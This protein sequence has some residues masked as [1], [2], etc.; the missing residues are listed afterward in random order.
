MHVDVSD[1][2]VT[3]VVVYGLPGAG[4]STLVQRTAEQLTLLHGWRA[5]VL[6]LDSWL[7]HRQAHSSSSTDAAPAFSP[8]DWH[9]AFDDFTDAIAQLLA[10]TLNDATPLPTVIFCVDNFYYASMRQRVQTM[11]ERRN[12]MLPNVAFVSVHVA[13]DTSVALLRNSQRQGQHRVP[14]AVIQRMA[15]LFEPGPVKRQPPSSEIHFAAIED[16]DDAASLFAEAIAAHVAQRVFVPRR[17]PPEDSESKDESRRATAASIVHQLDLLVRRRTSETLEF[18]KAG[19]AGTET[20][21]RLASH[22]GAAK[23]ALLQTA[24]RLRRSEADQDLLQLEQLGDTAA[25]VMDSALRA[26]FV[27]QQ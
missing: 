22:L 9:R 24:Q 12:E 5:H 25:A 16:R 6:E 13:V 26:A 27:E 15:M 11:V 8:V 14:D 23:R 2:N 18:A 7:H 4:K 19:G 10:A 3:V 20:L 1:G 17:P 21:K